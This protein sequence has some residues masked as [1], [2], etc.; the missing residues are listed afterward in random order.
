MNLKAEFKFLL[1][2]KALSPVVKGYEVMYR[3]V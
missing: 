2:S 3:Y 1:W